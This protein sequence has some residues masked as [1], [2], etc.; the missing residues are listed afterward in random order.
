M[1][2]LHF[3]VY[4]L[5][6]HIP[7]IFN[8]NSLIGLYDFE[9]I[10]VFKPDI[11][12][13][14]LFVVNDFLLKKTVFIADAIA[15]ARKT[16]RSCRIKEACHQTAK[17]AVSQRRVMFLGLKGFIVNPQLVQRFFNHGIPAQVIDVGF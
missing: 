8:H 13:L 16:Q 2:K 5:Y 10:A 7:V 9:G 17:A 15:V 14:N 4:L 11:R 6:T 3:A 1:D 12:N